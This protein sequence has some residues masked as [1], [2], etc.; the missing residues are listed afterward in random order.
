MNYHEKIL[1]MKKENRSFVTITVVQTTGST[2]GKTGFKMIV[3]RDK[4]IWGTVGGGALE[5]E[6]INE[7]HKLL[8]AGGDGILKEY[9]LTNDESIVDAEASVLPMT[10][11]GRIWLYY[12]PEQS[13][14]PVYIFGGGHVGQALIDILKNLNYCTILV[15]N[16]QEMYEI[17]KSK[18]VHCILS[19][20]NE[21]VEK[22]IPQDNSYFVVM[23]YGH[24]FDYDIVK[25][26]YK[27]N[28][29]KKYVG[30]IASKAKAKGILQSLKSDL[31]ENI[32][33]SKLHTPIG[34]MIGG[35]TAYEI[36]LSVAAQLQA[37][38]YEKNI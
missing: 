2:P 25:T 8:S 16:R 6:A 11:S 4:N 15:D 5:N 1:E 23:T 29:V 32:N 30:V 18:G 28:L 9:Y 12:E 37:V 31:E 13:L 20:Y 27:R 14:P 10:C 36:A 26:L 34:L 7:S 35:N 19:D 3:D 22:F 24:Q 33:L 38:R 17:N 21:F